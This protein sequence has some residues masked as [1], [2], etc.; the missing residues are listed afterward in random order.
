MAVVCGQYDNMSGSSEVT[1]KRKKNTIVLE[2]VASVHDLLSRSDLEISSPLVLALTISFVYN[3][4][5]SST[6]GS[7]LA[8]FLI[9]MKENF[10]EKKSIVFGH[11]FF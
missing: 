3:S 5:C 7:L 2:A 9:V 11:R 4:L 10:L 8:L 1:K 6:F